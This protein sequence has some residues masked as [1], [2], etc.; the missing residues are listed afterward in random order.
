MRKVLQVVLVMVLIGGV[1]LTNNPFVI[2]KRGE[3][4]Y[5]DWIGFE[6]N[7]N[8]KSVNKRFSDNKEDI[9]SKSNNKND[10]NE[11]IS[12]VPPNKSSKESKKNTENN[13]NAINKT[14]PEDYNNESKSN[15]EEYWSNSSEKSIDNWLQSLEP[16][17][18]K[19]E[20][21]LPSN[22]Q[23]REYESIV[24][25]EVYSYLNQ[26]RKNAGRP[27]LKVN[28]EIQSAAYVRSKELQT[29]YSHTRP[30]GKLGTSVLS[31]EYAGENIQK[32]E[33]YYDINKPS[34]EEIGQKIA[35][36]W[37]NSSGH[38]Q[39]I[40]NPEYTHQGVNVYIVAEKDANADKWGI[41]WSVYSAHL[42]ARI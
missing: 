2:E 42:F 30:N 33:S 25:N 16:D 41:K 22:T 31:Y 26:V 27:V 24:R 19:K 15:E 39:N 40:V 11:N 29:N 12:F 28:S 10:N 32:I 36:N 7:E 3:Q 13:T 5:I 35:K 20:A 17:I 14:K 18:E 9:N 21:V 4:Y 38:Y 6:E 37:E 34:W 23:L 8:D 1:T